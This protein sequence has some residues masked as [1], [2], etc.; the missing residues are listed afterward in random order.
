VEK[1]PPRHRDEITREVGD[2]AVHMRLLGEHPVNQ[3]LR[4]RDRETHQ[5]VP[6]DLQEQRAP[7]GGNSVPKVKH[8]RARLPFPRNK[9]IALC[10][11]AS[12]PSMR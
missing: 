3:R 7:F 9:A 11:N 1:I 5:S 4:T 10:C 2:L 6:H 12:N 8:M